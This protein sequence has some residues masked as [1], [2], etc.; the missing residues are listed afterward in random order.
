MDL[1]RHA[2]A[3]FAVNFKHIFDGLRCAP[4]IFLKSIFDQ[5]RNVGKGN[6]P[7]KKAGDGDFVGSIEHRGGRPALFQR[8]TSQSKGGKSLKIGLIEVE[9]R[10]MASDSVRL[11][12][13]ADQRITIGARAASKLLVEVSE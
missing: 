2:S 5:A 11:R 6:A 7:I 9:A 12:G 10:D 3:H 4:V 8:L 1:H 13:R